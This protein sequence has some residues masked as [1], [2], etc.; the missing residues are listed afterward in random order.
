LVLSKFK[1]YAFFEHQIE[2]LRQKRLLV[3]LV[4][5]FDKKASFKKNDTKILTPNLIQ[6]I[7]FN[8]NNLS[9]K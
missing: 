9:T 8:K 4:V 7:I 1:E 3:N 6:K 5:S 2:I